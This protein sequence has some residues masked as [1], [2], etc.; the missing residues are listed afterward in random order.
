MLQEFKLLH[1]VLSKQES[2]LKKKQQRAVAPVAEEFEEV[3]QLSEEDEVTAT[4]T[5]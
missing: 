3:Q 1:P 5:G 2:R 4:H